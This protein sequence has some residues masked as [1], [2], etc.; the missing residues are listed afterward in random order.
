[1]NPI[2]NL[3]IS[4]KLLSLIAL[5]LFGFFFFGAYSVFGLNAVKVNNPTDILIKQNKDLTSDILPP[6][7]YIIESYLNCLEMIVAVEANADSAVKEALIKKAIAL[8]RDYETRHAFWQNTLPDGE[9]KQLLLITSYQPAEAFY[10]TRD[11]DFIPAIRAGDIDKSKQILND[12]LFPKYSEHRAAIDRVVQKATDNNQTEELTIAATIQQTILV[13]IIFGIGIVLLTLLLGINIIRSI[14]KPLGTVTA[15][16]V[17]IAKGD[18]NQ[19]I[20]IQSHDEAGQMA[21]G[22]RQMTAYFQTLATEISKLASGDLSVQIQV[23]SKEDQLG[24]SMARMVDGLRATIKEVATNASKVDSASGQLASTAIQAG[25]ATSQIAATIQQIAKGTTQSTGSITRTAASVEQMTRA[26]DGVAKGAQNQA[27]AVG[28]ASTIT[29]KISAAIT[30]VTHAAQSG[31][32]GA[33]TAAATAEKGAETVR[34]NV[35]GMSSIKEK[36]NFSAT[37]VQEMGDRSKQIGAIVETIDE[38]AS[39]TN[40]LALNAAIEAARAG[41]HGKGFAVVAD[42]VRKLA[43]RSSAATKEI[44]DL[45]Q[46]VQHTVEEAVSAM[47]ASAKEVEIGSVQASQAGDALVSIL[48]AVEAVDQQMRSITQASQEMAQLSNELVAAMDSVSAVVEENTAATEQMAAG[49]SEV[50]QAIES[51]A[52]V[53]QENSAA[54]EEVSASTEQMTAQVEEVSATAQELRKMAAD[55]QQ[56]VAKFKV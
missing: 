12:S 35:S 40:L 14:T 47:G 8:R 28:Q 48:N 18:L 45:I 43:E 49:S 6:P 31:A 19:S 41:E 55:L 54:V 51:I 11:T 4:A 2:R 21:D 32:K 9:L 1:M 27:G 20:E 26:I 52:S 30:Q 50:T 16:A 24:K 39:Q 29:S 5:F 3:S 56:V 38:I 22:F 10:E 7:E 46:D 37:K 36:V 42:E 33:A 13:M 17:N 34:T 23:R 53:S 44:A 15:A 25:Q